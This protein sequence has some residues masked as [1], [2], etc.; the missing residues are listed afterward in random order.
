MAESQGEIQVVVGQARGAGATTIVQALAAEKA[1]TSQRT[2]MLDLDLWTVELSASYHQSHEN[3]LVQLAEQYWQEGV[4][5]SDAIADAVVPVQENLWLLP[6]SLH[7]LASSYLGGAHGYDFLRVLLLQLRTSFDSI[8][9]DLGSSIADLN[10]KTRPFLPACAAHLAA[11]ENAARIFYIF[12]SP[13][14]FE[15]WRAASP[16][17]EN[18]E[19]L[20]LLVNHAKREKREVLTIASQSIPLVFLKHAPE[21]PLDSTWFV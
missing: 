1:Q 7:W 17:V 3:R 6:N 20:C 13:V 18:P 16:R 8:V 14:E 4:L 15:K 2:L 5:S 19:K 9:V 10:T 21:G 11:V 12:A